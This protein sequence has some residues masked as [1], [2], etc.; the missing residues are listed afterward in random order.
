MI[1]HSR[2]EINKELLSSNNNLNKTILFSNQSPLMS[3]HPDLNGRI[4]TVDGSSDRD[5]SPNIT[6]HKVDIDFS[7]NSSK[8]ANTNPGAF[9]LALMNTFFAGQQINKRNLVGGSPK[10]EI[11]NASHLF[12]NMMFNEEE[13]VLIKG[14]NRNVKKFTCLP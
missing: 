9:Q 14:K 8:F 4:D 2:N 13:V 3:R 11:K 7:T 5:V 1:I 10:K 12:D 6:Q